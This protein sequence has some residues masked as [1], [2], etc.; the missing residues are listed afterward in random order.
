MTTLNLFKNAKDTEKYET[1]ALIFKEGDP[2]DC[3]FAVVEGEVDIVLNDTVIDTLSSGMILGEMGLIEGTPRSATA[4]A[5]TPV[6]LV[7]V[8]E[9][10]FNFLVQQTPFFALQMM[11]IISS[12]LRKRMSE[13]D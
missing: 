7:R 12:R 6:Q 1:D 4:R 11:R 8:D 13:Q 5:K 2:A 10:R 3:M 9:R